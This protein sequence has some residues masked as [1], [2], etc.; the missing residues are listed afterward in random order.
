MLHPREVTREV[1]RKVSCGKVSCLCVFLSLFWSALVGCGGRAVETKAPERR[2]LAPSQV[3]AVVQD[4]FSDLGLT[5]ERSWAVDLGS[6]AG[7]VHVDYRAQGTPYGIH[8]IQSSDRQAH[9]D[10][11]PTPD[12]HGQLKLMQ[13]VRGDA[14]AQVLALD[15][16]TYRYT[17]DQGRSTGS[18]RSSSRGTTVGTGLIEVTQRLRRDVEDFVHYFQAQP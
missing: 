10:V 6:A 5:V 16:E 1:A 8:W 7:P 12:P 4:V 2:T 9:G 15:A 11:L 3:D 18:A 14:Q 13:G 17:L